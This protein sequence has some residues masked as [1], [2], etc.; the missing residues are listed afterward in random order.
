[1]VR[2]DVLVSAVGNAG[3]LDPDN[4]SSDKTRIISF[5]NDTRRELY[6]LPYD[7][8]FLEFS[9]EISGTENVTAG[10]VKAT[11]DQVEVTGTSTS[12][13]TAMAGRYI[14]IDGQPF[15]RVN[16]ISDST[17][18]SLE[19]VWPYSSV[20]DKSYILWKRFY[21]LP[22][23]V[24]KVISIKDPSQDRF[25]DYFDFYEFQHRFRTEDLQSNPNAY[26]SFGLEEVG[27]GFLDS[28]VFTGVTSTAN[29]PILDFSGTGLS[30]ALAP[31]SQVVFG[32]STTST[33]FYVERVL[34][35]TKVSLNSRVDVTLGGYSATGSNVGR[36][37][38]A[39]YPSLDERT[40]LF[41]TGKKRLVNLSSEDDLIEDEWYTA[42]KLGSTAKALE[43]INSPKYS[44]KLGEYNAATQNLIRLHK[45]HDPF[46][47]LKPLLPR[48]YGVQVRGQGGRWGP[49]TV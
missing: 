9:G 25:L 42:I 31:G 16:Y 43:Y 34:T 24:S 48:R 40:I 10:T 22:P 36:Q 19:T 15:Q 35:D 41:Y 27:L 33:A 26:S 32:D 47:R 30:T 14:A 7:F 17:H 18:L 3:G 21:A 2:L 23:L 6:T 5:I 45:R 4:V 46:P 38:V 12:F 20:T 44:Q 13:T 8:P 28:T 49:N 37:Y 1:M 11:K 29:S 39:F